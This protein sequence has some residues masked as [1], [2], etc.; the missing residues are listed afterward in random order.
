[1]PIKSIDRQLVKSL[2][3]FRGLDDAGL[4]AVLANARSQFVEARGVLGQ[5]GA[6]VEAVLIIVSGRIKIETVMPDG[7][8]TVL[9]ILGP[10]SLIGDAA[11]LVDGDG[12]ALP[13]DSWAVTSVAQ[14]D[15]L[16]LIIDKAD[17]RAHMASNVR[18]ACNVASSLAKRLR[19]MI[20]RDT[21][22]TALAVPARLARIIVW[23]ADQEGMA[24]GAQARLNLRIAQEQLGAMIGATRESVNKYLRDWARRG[25]LEHVGG[26]I[27]ILDVDGLRALGEATA[28]QLRV[29]TRG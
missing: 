22:M 4:D 16:V 14:E 24:G 26:H 1:M 20:V 11:I 18:F 3:V 27:T 21:W 6:T 19:M 7:E 13:Q 9:G 2:P 12:F 5:S 25:L 28:E 29:I 8:G 10:G 15:C 23:L 17:F